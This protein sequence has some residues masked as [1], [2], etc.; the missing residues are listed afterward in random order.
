MDAVEDN[1]T[2]EM[3]VASLADK[4][5]G[6]QREGGGKSSLSSLK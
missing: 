6:E 1:V 4:R 5:N 2:M 3:S